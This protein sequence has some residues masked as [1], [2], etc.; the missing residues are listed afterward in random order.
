MADRPE[1]EAA[2]SRA[3]TPTIE[4]E[5]GQSGIIDMASVLFVFF[6]FQFTTN[7]CHAKLSKHYCI[8][9]LRAIVIR[10]LL[11]RIE[12]IWF[13]RSLKTLWTTVI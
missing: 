1:E 12:P 7:K 4:E 11:N 5:P 13:L 8:V 10:R 2:S 6:V 3:V 9:G